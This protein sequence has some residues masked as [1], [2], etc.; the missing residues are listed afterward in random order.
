MQNGKIG[1]KSFA[2]VIIALMM[3]SLAPMAMLIQ[4][5]EAQTVVPAGV[6]PTNV[7]S[8]GSVPLP[9]GV[10]PDVTIDTIATLSFTPNPIGVGQTLLVNLWLHPATHTSRY[11]VGYTVTFTKPDGTTDQKV[12]NS[13]QA[14]TTA[15]FNYQVDQVGIWKV[16]F[17]F[18]GGYFPA[19]NY[20]AAPGAF[21]GPGPFS[22]T[23]SVYYKPSSDGPYNLTVQQ[24]QVQSWPMAPLPTDY[25]TRPA[26][27]TN[28]EWWPILGNYPGTGILGGGTNWPANTNTYMSNYLFTPYVQGPNTCHVV[29]RRQGA[30]DDIQWSLLPHANKSDVYTCQRYLC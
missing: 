4:P 17:D 1:N 15:W 8:S 3:A 12:V 27:P 18:P 24:E 23:Q 19:G 21:T 30:D 13:Y 25:W 11:L 20:S 14:D 26:Q 22:F 28:R 5:V 10:T 6:T 2:L 9:S 7:Q 29:W 16:K